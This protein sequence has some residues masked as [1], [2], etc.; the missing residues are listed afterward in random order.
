M[1]THVATRPPL[2]PPLVEERAHRLGH[3]AIV[4]LGLVAGGL[5]GGLAALLL[6]RPR[7][8]AC[9]V[10]RRG[11]RWW[12]AAAGVLALLTVVG[13]GVRLAGDAAVPACPA[14]GSIASGGYLE[15][16][17]MPT[18]PTSPRLRAVL[19]APASG[20]AVGWARARGETL[21]GVGEPAMTLAFVPEARLTGGSTVGDVFLTAVRPDLTRSEAAALA[22]HESRHADQWAVL[23]AVGGIA[24]LPVSYLVDESMFP[25]PSNHFE[26]S[27]GLA[28]GG[29][30]PAPQPEEPQPVAL[31]SWLVVAAVAL[32]TSLRALCRTAIRRRVV[33]NPGRCAR[34][35]PGWC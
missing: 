34:H 1:S 21:C 6:A 29:Y 26:Q 5:L 11:L 15:G 23:T 14:A 33:R 19:T 10:C 24:L 20:L 2:P 12:G 30:P 32:R 9:T 22:R 4:V 31:A 8:L 16:G 28:A 13:T 25:G 3:V 18:V 17:T 35:T 7:R 27:A